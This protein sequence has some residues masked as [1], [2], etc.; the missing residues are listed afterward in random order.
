[1]AEKD[2]VARIYSSDPVQIARLNKKGYRR[3]KEYKDSTGVYAIEY[4]TPIPCISFRSPSKR[5]TLTEEQRKEVGRRL[6]M[7]RKKKQNK[8][9]E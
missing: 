9:K 6:A 2:K 7:A 8:D 3:I 4:E 1:M 5:R